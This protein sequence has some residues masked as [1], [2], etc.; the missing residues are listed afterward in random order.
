MK[1]RAP[2]VLVLMSS[3][4]VL[5]TVLTWIIPPGQY[6]RIK[7][8]IPGV[9]PKDIVALD[10][11]GKPTFNEVDQEKQRIEG[12][13]GWG[14]AVVVGHGTRQGLWQLL[15]APFHGFG[16]HGAWK[17][18]GFILLIGGA[19]GVL[20][21]TGAIMAGLMWLVTA[22]GRK[23]RFIM[24][25]VLMFAFSAA[26][27]S[28]GMAEESIAFAL[29]TVPLAVAMRFDVITGI[30][31][32]FVGSQAGFAT[33]FVNPF[34]YAI[35]KQI[36]GVPIDEGIA[37]RVVCWLV[38]T[39]VC[40]AF[41]TWHAWRVFKDPR[42]SLTPEI[43]IQWRAKMTED[44]HGHEQAT[45]RDLWVIVLFLG[46]M[47]FLTYGSL[48][49]DDWRIAEMAAVFLGMCVVCGKIGG[50][51]FREMA[52]SFM[53]GAKDLAPTA[54]L[55]A[56]ARAIL[57]MAE[58][59]QIIDPILRSTSDALG[60]MGTLATTECMYGVQ[61]FINF[62]VPSGSSQAALTMP[63]MAPLAELRGLHP[64]N[65]V[66]AYQFGDGLSNIIIPTNPVLMG[67]I[68]V[69]GVG[70][71]SWFRWVIKIQL[72]LWAVGALLLAMSPFVSA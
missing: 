43:D 65:A 6:T 13:T 14:K 37:Y 18:I 5:M 7:K 26:G 34:T 61:T 38:V 55:L 4:L 36:A 49:I 30:A 32:P 50:L 48:Y 71:G 25:P 64:E 17:V 67:V 45:K 63:I 53:T 40:A 70:Y 27:V 31:I 41:V 42:K 56:F 15:Q 72:L 3:I 22:T 52:E 54:I 62:F 68:S 23:G 2:N 59:G 11:N 24:V 1:L 47:A 44:A 9:G 58:G 35:A 8:T 21:K 57:L 39:A 28:F 51:S 16:A 46:S 20:N 29:I 66:L 60:G 10:E 33:A 69:A 19:F 12:I